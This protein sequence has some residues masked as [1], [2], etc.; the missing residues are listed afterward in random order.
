MR[1]SK[2]RKLEIIDYSKA[3]K[4]LEE[5]CVQNTNLILFGEFGNASFPSIS[6]LDVFICLEDQNFLED[7]HKIIDFIDSDEIRQYLFFHDPL[8]ISESMLK[9]LKQFH[10]LY[11][12]NFTY[13]KK[14]ILITDSNTEQQELLNSIWTT[15][16]M[17]IGPGILINPKLDIRDK[18]LVLKNICQSIVNIDPDSD[19]L[20]FNKETRKQAIN[21]LLTLVDVNKIFKTKLIELYQISENLQFG[22]IIDLKRKK[23]KIERNMIIVKDDQNSFSF[24]EGKIYIHLNPEYF[25]FFSQFYNKAS[26]NPRIQIYIENAISLNKLCRKIKI[27]YPFIAPFGF[28]FY[29]N[30]V[31]FYVKKIILAI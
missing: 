4:D 19:A 13:N 6:D 3:Y 7:Q 28:L 24:K 30:D 26:M 14:N 17:V 22:N 29:R 5:Y 31:K 11:N 20:Y 25:N 23:Y 10:T 15:Y 1:N 21:G 18:L 27:S 8:I 2:F 12:L 16:I 9:F